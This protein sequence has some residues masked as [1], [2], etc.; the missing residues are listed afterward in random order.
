[1]KK[2][3]AIKIIIFLLAITLF[4]FGYTTFFSNQSDTEILN[5]P[6]EENSELF[7]FP[8]SENREEVDNFE[9]EQINTEEVN[10]FNLPKL[11][12][13]SDVP[14]SGFTTFNRLATTSTTLINNDG[15]EEQVE[16]EY[17]E[18]VFR[19][20]N[21]SNSHIYETTTQNPIISRITNTTIPKIYKT[22]FSSDGE[23][24][25]LQYL[26]E[27]NEI[28]TY[29]ADIDES[30][31]TPKTLS[32]TFL[33]RNIQEIT[34][35]PNTDNFFYLL[36][37]PDSKYINIS[38]GYL[39]NIEN[40]QNQDFIFESK[41]TEWTINWPTQNNITITTKPTAEEGGV[42]FSLNPNTGE[43]LK[44]LDGF[45]GFTTLS[46]SDLSK[47]LYSE[48]VGG[49]LTLNV[50]NNE[51]KT[52]TE[53][54]LTT[55]PEK[56]VWSELDLNIVFCAIPESLIGVGYPDIWYKGEIS[57]IDQ[58]YKI[59]T[60]TGLFQKIDGINTES[61]TEQFDIINPQ[62]TPDEDY[63]LFQNK[64]DL[65]LWSFDIIN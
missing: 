63:L 44:I 47:V 29:V 1:M 60:E 28:K 2:K 38:N 59:N 33:N 10:E 9:I 17:Q 26:D 41:L 15:V 65:T 32:G 49:I 57:H 14:V 30:T 62:L 3:T 16:Q 37:Q 27:V 55:L 20:M 64:K 25:V 42:M 45:A 11:R 43:S 31:S 8:T 22:I 6:T 35:S 46:N 61:S 4:Y 40:T 58:I 12:Q 23:S 19:Y 48:N 34:K 21:R 51:L 36:K 50:F 18:T 53:L 5:P 52:K 56:C 7:F 39:F 13:I 24:V 54:R